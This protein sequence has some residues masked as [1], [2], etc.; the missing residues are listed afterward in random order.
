MKIDNFIHDIEGKK[1]TFDVIRD[2]VTYKIEI[3]K[4]DM[5]V[6]MTDIED[7]TEFWDYE[8]YSQLD[9]FIGACSGIVHCFY[10]Y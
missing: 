1:I 5:G 9:D 2:G 3:E 6:S 8:S 7:F 4:S 10:H